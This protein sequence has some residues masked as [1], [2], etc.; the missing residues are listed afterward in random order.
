MELDK[1]P[2]WRGNHVEIRQLVE[3]FARYIYLPRLKSPEVLLGA[4]RDGLGLLTWERETFAFADGFDAQA[5]RYVGLRVGRDVPALATDASGMLV[6]PEVASQQLTA[7]RAQAHPAGELPGA[8]G[9]QSRPTLATREQAGAAPGPV[10]QRNRRFHGSVELNPVRVGG[11]AGR[12]AEEVIAHLAALQNAK[13]RISLEIEVHVPE[14][15]PDQVQRVVTENCR[16]LRF[17]THGFEP[18]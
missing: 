8:T 1:V 12:V 17:V 9:E 4:V 6:R 15:I 13:V 7:E 10:A 18:E 14:G 11:D 2:L 16:T 3:D 5:N